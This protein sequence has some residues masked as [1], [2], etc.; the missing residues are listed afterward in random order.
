M[1][2]PGPARYRPEP[3]LLP[4]YRL[5]AITIRGD[6]RRRTARA[7]VCAA[8]TARERDDYNNNNII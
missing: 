1:R 7:A 3:I 8:D 2:D 6:G 5:S 4:G